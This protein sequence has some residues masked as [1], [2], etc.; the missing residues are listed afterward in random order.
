MEHPK[1]LCSKGNQKKT[2]LPD[3]AEE[4][5][6]VSLVKLNIH[7]ILKDVDISFG[8]TGFYRNANSTRLCSHIIWGKIALKFCTL[9]RK[10]IV[11]PN[12]EKDQS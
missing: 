10:L 1:S 12:F 9:I 3:S 5:N 7:T 6:M 8:S 4:D 11:C 2:F